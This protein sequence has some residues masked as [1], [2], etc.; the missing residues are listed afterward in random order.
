[1]S[2]DQTRN[3]S[4]TVQLNVFIRVQIASGQYRNARE[5]VR[6]ALRLLQRQHD[7]EERKRRVLV[8]SE[9][10]ARHG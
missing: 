1:M 4:L 10:R 2:T 6:S 3:V 8:S 5:V 7:R 9:D